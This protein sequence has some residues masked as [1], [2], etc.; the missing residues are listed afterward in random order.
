MQLTDDDL[1]EFIKLWREEFH[2]EISMEE[3]RKRGTEL[4]EL[5]W[6]LS[7]PLPSELEETKAANLA[8]EAKSPLLPNKKVR[9]V[10]SL[11]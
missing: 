6:L 8:G 5:Y 2:E 9:T 1:E 7:R 11:L 10:P 3:A 4:I